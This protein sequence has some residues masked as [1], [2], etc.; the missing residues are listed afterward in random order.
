MNIDDLKS[1]WQRA[2][3]E[4]HSEQELAMMTRVRNHPTLRGLRIKFVTEIAALTAFLLLYYDG[5]DGAQKPMIIN[6]LLIFSITLY[7]TTNALGYAQIQ[8][9]RVSG[10]I[11]E[12]LAR[13][14]QSLKRMAALSLGSSVVYALALV[15]FLTY[16]I[17]FNQRKYIIL[18]GL[19]IGFILLFY[20][21]LISWRRKIS[22][23]EAMQADF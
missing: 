8:N 18:S 14:V 1:E 6:V 11:R 3:A 4:P 17:E 2:G 19:V 21:S 7:V 12:A 13:R 20:Y 23:F 22:H 10:N 5:F 16:Q 15:A 9:P